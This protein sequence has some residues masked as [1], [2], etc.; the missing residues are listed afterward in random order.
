MR[1]VNLPRAKAMPT[2][3]N[4]RIAGTV[5]DGNSGQTDAA[6][7]QDGHG[8]QAAT[9]QVN[10]GHTEQLKLGHG[11]VLGQVEGE[12]LTPAAMPAAMLRPTLRTRIPK[13]CPRTMR[14]HGP[15]ERQTL[16]PRKSLNQNGYGVT[17]AENAACKNGTLQVEYRT[18]IQPSNRANLTD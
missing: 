5:T 8:E 2:A 12:E 17:Q 15:Q 10:A 7:A 11:G 14:K 9:P 18:S 13:S 3:K 4:T 1:T 6:Q 16:L